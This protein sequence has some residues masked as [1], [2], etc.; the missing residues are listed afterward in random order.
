MRTM[1]TTGGLT[2]GRGMAE[3]QRT[4]WLLSVPACSSVN[5]AMQKLTEADYVTS[6]QQKDA[7]PARQSTRIPEVSLTT[8]NTE[9]PLS[10]TA[11]SL[12]R[13]L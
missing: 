13:V 10:M 11:R 7:T 2:R 8:Y 3:S 4:Q 5:A 9:I 12:L 6:D 1:K